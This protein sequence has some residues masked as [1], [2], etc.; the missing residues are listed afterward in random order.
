MHVVTT[1]LLSLLLAF[2]S[3]ARA[4]E[5]PAQESPEADAAAEAIADATEEEWAPPELKYQTGSIVLPNKIATLELTDAYRYLDPAE[6]EKLLVAWGNPPGSEFQGAV[7]PAN[8]SP[9]DDGGWAVLVDYIDEG[10]VED[11]DAAEI[12]YDDMLK[13]MKSDTREGSKEREKAGYGTVELMGWAQPPRYDAATR[14]L[15]WAKELRFNG[16]EPHTLNYDVR[17]LGREGVLSLNAVAGMPQVD[18]VQ[19]DMQGLLAM[20]SF[21]PGHRYEEYNASTDRTAAYGIGALVAGG[22]AAKAG[23]FAKIGALLLAFK[24]FIIIGLVALGG[25]LVSLFR[26]RKAASDSPIS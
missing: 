19:K 8:L 25:F 6:T 17:V 26:R 12:D 3:I 5:A 7:V 13:D 16:S 2:A 20:A 4:Q 22:L 15:Y 23:L 24:K 1:L 11:A 14:K 21:N 18:M 10:H 9:F